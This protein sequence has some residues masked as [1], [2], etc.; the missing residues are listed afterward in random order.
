MT[1]ITLFSRQTGNVISQHNDASQI[2]ALTEASVIAINNSTDWATGYIRTGDDLSLTTQNGATLQYQHFFA[3][4]SQGTLVFDNGAGQATQAVFTAAAEARNLTPQFEAYRAPAADALSRTQANAADVEAA[5]TPT[6]TINTF[7]GD[8]IITYAEGQVDQV[9]SGTTT[10]IEAGQSLSVSFSDFAYFVTEVQADGS[11]QMVLNAASMYDLLRYG[12]TAITASAANAAGEGA[13][14]SVP[15]QVRSDWPSVTLNAFAGD[16]VISGPEDQAAQILSG[17]STRVEAGQTVTLTLNGHTYTA[18]VDAEGYWHTSV[19]AA[20]VAALPDGAQLVATVTNALGQQAGD[21]ATLPDGPLTVTASG[22]D[23]A[24]SRVTTFSGRANG[25]YTLVAELTAPDADSE[26]TAAALTVTGQAADVES[27]DSTLTPAPAAPDT[28]T[29][30][31]E[32][33]YAIGGQTLTLTE[34]GGE[35]LGGSGTDTLL[36]AGSDQHL[37]LTTLGLKIEHIDIFDLGNGHN[38]LTLGLHEAQAVRDTPEESL[39]IRGADGSQ[40]V[41]TGDNTWETHGQRRRPGL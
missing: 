16:N 35:A 2:I 33:T 29:G 4:G 23:L 34:S 18:T 5:D 8:N 22:Y 9:L 26:E 1:A 6:I 13:S 39:F 12:S 10:G 32:G 21:S 7:A 37:D 30:P 40:L 15:F 14:V 25:V 38:S 11:W 20:D 31:A 19:P 24:G 28:A 17:S 41:L 36:L 3:A 27:A